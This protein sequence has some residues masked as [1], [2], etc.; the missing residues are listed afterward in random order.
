MMLTFVKSQLKSLNDDATCKEFGHL[1]DV[2]CNWGRGEDLLDFITEHLQGT[3]ADL[4]N[5]QSSGTVAQG[6][7]KGA[8]VLQVFFKNNCDL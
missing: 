1:I 6:R 3:L 4:L 2:M 5:E 7:R 8:I